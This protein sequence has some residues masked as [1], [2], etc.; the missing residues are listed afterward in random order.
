MSFLQTL[1]GDD[2]SLPRYAA[3]QGAAGVVPEGVGAGNVNAEV[4]EIV[5]YVLKKGVAVVLATRVYHG[6]VLSVYSDQGGGATMER[7]G[8]NLGGDLTGPKARIL[9]MMA[10]SQIKGY[11]GRLRMIHSVSLPSSRTQSFRFSIE[12]SSSSL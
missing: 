5:E 2:G 3:D 7:G 10:L 9:L 6:G 4:F 8:V 11:H 12:I 1:A